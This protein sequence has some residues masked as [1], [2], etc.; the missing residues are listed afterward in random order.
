MQPYQVNAVSTWETF[1]LFRPL[2]TCSKLCCGLL[3]G[4][5]PRLS[6]AV[7]DLH[8]RNK[9]I[10]ETLRSL[11]SSCQTSMKYNMQSI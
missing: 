3:G 7:I 5:Q 8:N 4:G 1:V 11:D 6:L 10:P 9:N 2:L